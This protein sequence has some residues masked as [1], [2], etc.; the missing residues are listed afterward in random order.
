MAKLAQELAH[1]DMVLEI[2]R[3]QVR[4]QPLDLEGP[5][6]GAHSERPFQNGAELGRIALCP[7]P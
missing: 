6:R 7:D 5:G 2:P 4:W 3:R 1:A